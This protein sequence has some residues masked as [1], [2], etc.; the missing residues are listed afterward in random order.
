M[1]KIAVTLEELRQANKKSSVPVHRPPRRLPIGPMTVAKSSGKGSPLTPGVYQ[2]GD[3]TKMTS[4]L[5]ED[6]GKQ[7]RNLSPSQKKRLEK[8]KKARNMSPAG[9]EVYNRTVRQHEI[10]EY[11]TKP[12]S[13]A[14]R[15]EGHITPKPPLQDLNIAAT[16]KGKGSEAADVIRA[17]RGR[18]I[19]QLK[20]LVPGA[21]R[22]DLGNKRLS[23]HA[24]K[25]LVESYERNN[26]ARS[27]KANAALAKSILS[28][29]KLQREVG[30]KKPK[31]GLGR[32]IAA[33]KKRFARKALTRS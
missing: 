18:E 12:R 19:D 8:L 31:R 2:R 13:S 29:Q 5:A 24:I 15:M 6:V 23:R 21:R 28:G 10:A 25:R 17:Q 7:R 14:A 22:L 26:A 16:L 20:R 1:Q 9:R 11:T 3:V 30:L 27:A 4:E 32:M 33:L